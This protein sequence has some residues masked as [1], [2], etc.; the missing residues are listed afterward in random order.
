MRFFK[1]YILALGL[2][3]LLDL[4]WLGFVAKDVYKEYIG[5]LMAKQIK[6]V[7]SI[8]AYAIYIAGL[9]FFAL[10]P[11][12]DEEN[13]CSALLYGAFFGFVCYA[14]YNFTNLAILELWNR[15][16]VAYDLFWGT[17]ASGITSLLTFLIARNWKKDFT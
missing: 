1:L 8:L 12:L 13:P 14:T 6:W 4:F 17:F 3:C 9:V 5:I 2:F 15:R 7:P 16:I 10:V 11:A